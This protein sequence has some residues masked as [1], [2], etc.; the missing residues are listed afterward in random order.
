MFASMSYFGRVV[1]DMSNQNW[2]NTGPF[3]LGFGN[4]RYADYALTCPMLIMDLLF[5]L[6]APYKIT[7]ALMIHCM[8]ISGVMANFYYGR[9]WPKGGRGPAIAWFLY[10]SY[11]YVVAFG[12]LAHIVKIQYGKLAKLAEGTE[13]KKALLPLRISIVT[14]FTLWLCYPII[15]ILG[16]QGVQLITFS[17][18]ECIHA[19]CDIVAKSIYG[20]TLARFKSYYDRKLCQLLDACGLEVNEE[21]EEIERR[22]QMEGS[23]KMTDITSSH[24]PRNSKVRSF[25]SEGRDEER[26]MSPRGKYEPRGEKYES[27]ASRYNMDDY[28]APKPTESVTETMQQ[29]EALNKQLAALMSNR[30]D[31]GAR[32]V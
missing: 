18:V 16:D 23:S 20:F 32:P 1:S 17:G 13:A 29:I 11:W 19:F 2:E 15:W 27:R 8:L 30:A 9:N 6:R 3:I 26:N 5:C 7:M 4:Y 22:L 25:D 28:A 24:S 10:S 14:I 31:P 12:V 21:F